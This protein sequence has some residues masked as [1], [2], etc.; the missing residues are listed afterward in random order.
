MKRSSQRSKVPKVEQEGL[1]LEFD[2]DTCADC[3]MKIGV[4]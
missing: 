1:S 4:I 2:P 3:G